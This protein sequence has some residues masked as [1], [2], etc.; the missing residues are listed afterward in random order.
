MAMEHP[1]W[2]KDKKVA[3]DF[4]VIRKDDWDSYKDFIMDKGCYTL[5]RTYPDTHEIG[6]AICNPD[7][8]ILKEFRGRIAQQIYDT[9]FRYDEDN[10]KGWFTRMEHAAYLGKEL[11]KAEISLVLGSNY[12]QE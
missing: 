11:K 7:H 9:L 1:S 4:E 6:V 2:I 10:K 12:V 3:K 8:T 5:I